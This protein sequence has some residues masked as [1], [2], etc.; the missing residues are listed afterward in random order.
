MS[1]VTDPWLVEVIGRIGYDVVWFDLEHRLFADG[2]VDAIALACRHAGVDLMVRI[3]K[4]GYDSAMR[5]LEAGANGIMVPHIR[6]AA[7]AREWV[8][9]VR[10]PPLGKRGL[11]GVGA[12]ADHGFAN[13]LDHIKHAN[14]EVFLALQI[15]DKEAVE[16]IEEIAAVPGFDLLFVGPGDL[17]LSYGVPL[18]FEHPLIESA[19]QR[20]AE[21]AAKHGKWWGTTSGNATQAQRVLDR[22]GRMFTA[23]GDHGALV[24][25]LKASFE[26]CGGV[27]IRS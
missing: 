15:E 4:H 20:V 12:D 27:A 19:Y 2:K 11:D 16:Q 10:F 8:N 7:E 22:G 1:R 5:M 13:T 21:A 24:N 18:Q 25:G 17:T 23:G 6:S 26:A 3:R 9:Y 14:E